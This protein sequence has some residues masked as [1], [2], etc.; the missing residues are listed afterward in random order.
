VIV[1]PDKRLVIHHAR[2]QADVVA[3]RTI[4]SDELRLDPPGIAL[5]VAELFPLS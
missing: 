3:T 1:D 5:V 2:A 4:G